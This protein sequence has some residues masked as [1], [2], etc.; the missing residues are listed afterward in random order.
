VLLEGRNQLDDVKKNS[1]DK[2]PQADNKR[3]IASRT[4]FINYLSGNEGG[5]NRGHFDRCKG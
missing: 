4:L 5:T 2:E 1:G 3:R